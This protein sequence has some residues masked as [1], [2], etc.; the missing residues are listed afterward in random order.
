MQIT[1]IAKVMSDRDDDVFYSVELVHNGDK[2][3]W[4]CSCPHNVYR[5]RVCKHID[6]AKRAIAGEKVEGVFLAN[7]DI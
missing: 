3:V 7:E 6:R 4:A 5:G 1:L 2:R